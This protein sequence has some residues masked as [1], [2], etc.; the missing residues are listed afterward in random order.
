MSKQ[1]HVLIA[2]SGPSSHN[3]EAVMEYMKIPYTTTLT[4][5]SPD[6]YDM[7]LLPGG[8]DIYPPLYAERNEGSR[9][10][11]ALKDLQQLTLLDD[12]IKKGKPVMGICKGFQLIQIYFGGDLVQDL[13][14][15]TAHYHPQKDILHPADNKKGSL[16]ESIYGSSC[17]INSCHHQ[18]V[19]YP[20]PG[21]QAVQTGPDTVIEAMVHSAFPVLGIQW[22]PE[23]LCLKF[24]NPGAVNGLL[25]FQRF[26]H[27][28][29]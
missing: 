15:D 9:N 13:V 8:G 4:S 3:Y 23:R 24:R 11:E 14:P 27:V 21:L 12:F 25:I 29:L 1:P 16:L 28:Y 18:A 2:Q 22:H 7:L 10:I 20:A 5:V 17:I 6:S 19:L 26:L